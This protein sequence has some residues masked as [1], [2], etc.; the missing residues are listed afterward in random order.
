MTTHHL[1][2]LPTAKKS[3]QDYREEKNS[4]CEGYLQWIYSNIIY[5]TGFLFSKKNQFKDLLLAYEAKK[6]N[7]EDLLLQ[8]ATKISIKKIFAIKF[9]KDINCTGGFLPCLSKKFLKNQ[10]NECLLLQDLKQNINVRWFLYQIW[11]Q[12]N[13]TTKICSTDLKQKYQVWEFL[14]R[15]DAK[16]TFV[17]LFSLDLAQTDLQY[18][19]D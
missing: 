17:K 14:L 15:F 12:I 7:C 18:E 16:F 13:N 10:L 19:L 6:T 9:V 3:E 8:F 1:T 4:N 5:C 11:S 2:L